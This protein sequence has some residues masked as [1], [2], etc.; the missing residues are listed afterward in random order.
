MQ[1]KLREDDLVHLSGDMRVDYRLEAV[2]PEEVGKVKLMFSVMLYHT[3]GTSQQRTA[4]Y[5]ITDGYCI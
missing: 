1:H 3:P 2:D 4:R 5:I